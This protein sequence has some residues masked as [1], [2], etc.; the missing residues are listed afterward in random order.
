MKSS[1]AT[2]T[3]K[4]QPPLQWATALAAGLTCYSLEVTSTC[5]VRLVESPEMTKKV[6]ASSGL[7]QNVLAK[8]FEGIYAE[9]LDSAILRTDNGILY[10]FKR[11]DGDKGVFYGL[12][13]PSAVTVDGSVWLLQQTLTDNVERGLVPM[14]ESGNLQYIGCSNPTPAPG[15]QVGPK[16]TYQPR[17]ENF[18]FEGHPGF[19]VAASHRNAKEFAQVT[20]DTTITAGDVT[21][22][23]EFGVVTSENRAPDSAGVFYTQGHL[24]RST[25]DENFWQVHLKNNPQTVRCAQ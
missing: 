2:P 12:I 21:I 16:F 22:Q 18:T 19:H 6:N 5:G 8:D 20:K 17:F 7:F 3:K 4:V 13:Q 25:V 11:G 15:D 9:G 10:T 1:V 24:G 23:L 14:K